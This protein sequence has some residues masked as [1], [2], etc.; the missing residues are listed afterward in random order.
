VGPDPRRPAEPAVSVVLPVHNERETLATLF[1]EI[2]VALHDRRIEIVAV[3]DASIDGSDAELARLARAATDVR[4]LRLGR[5]S[6]QSAALVA[7]WVAARAPV[8]VTLDADGQ[9][10]PE[11]IPRLLGTL[12]ADP[13]LGAVV[14]FREG[15]RDS[16]WRRL[17][18]VIANRARDAI[19]GH[20][21]RDT[22]C[23]LKVIRRRALARLPQ[24]DGM[25]RFLPTLLVREGVRI[26]EAPV[27]HRARRHGRTKYGM[28]N[29][30]FR[31]LRDAFGVRWL[32]RRALTA[33]WEEVT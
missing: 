4:V 12:M 19:T 8:V 31:G 18:A 1:E 13:S 2:R 15:R 22:G 17:Q 11:D 21:V 24:F 20:R 5:R 23:G 28:W 29:R 7:G 30:V 33:D 10:D 32:R 16:G 14:G 25:H 26:A 9:N 27:S 3:D 6:G